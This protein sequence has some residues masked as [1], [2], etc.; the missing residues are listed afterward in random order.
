MAR[1]ANLVWID[2]EM[3]GLDPEQCTIVEIATI[4]TNEDLEV[5][6]EGPCLVVHQPPDVMAEMSDEVR[7][8]HERSGL[9]DLISAST[10]SLEEAER[11]SL[12]FIKEHCDERTSPLCGNSI[13]KDRQFLERYMPTLAG[14]LHYRVIDVSTIKELARRWYGARG[15]SPDKAERHR[16]LD[17]IR[18]SIQELRWYREQLFSAPTESVR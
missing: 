12:E 2:L 4:I 13:W 1:D 3:T 5:L 9:I 16:A 18:E 8:L 17:D 7:K 11:A 6:A 10:T 14:Y 15:T